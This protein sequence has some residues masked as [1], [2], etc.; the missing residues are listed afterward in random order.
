MRNVEQPRIVAPR[1]FMRMSGENQA[2]RL[3]DLHAR[4]MALTQLSSL[5]ANHLVAVMAEVALYCGSKA[6]DPRLFA[7]AL[8]RMPASQIVK[9]LNLYLTINDQPQVAFS[10][11]VNV[12]TVRKMYA[13]RVIRCLGEIGKPEKA[14]SVLRMPTFRAGRNEICRAANMTDPETFRRSVAVLHQPLRR[15]ILMAVAPQ[16]R[17][18][19]D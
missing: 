1:T 11:T 6:I 16:D 5:P 19:A 2:T 15:Q 3:I 13:F 14:E 9:A 7:Q 4:E 8:G 12:G 17:L 18:P 10:E